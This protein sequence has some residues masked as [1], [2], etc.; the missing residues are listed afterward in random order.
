M[1]NRGR[2]KLDARGEQSKYLTI[3]TAEP[4]REECRRAPERA[5]IPLSE[6]VRNRLNKAAKRES[7]G[8]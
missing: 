3:R 1:K 4:E 5:G 2:P 6:W 8:L 7:K